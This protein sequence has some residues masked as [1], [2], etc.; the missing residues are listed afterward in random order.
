MDFFFLLFYEPQIYLFRQNHGYFHMAIG[1]VPLRWCSTHITLTSYCMFILCVISLWISMDL[2]VGTE[3]IS[4]A[5][6]A[7]L[8]CILC[9]NI[10]S[11]SLSVYLF[12]LENEIPPLESRRV[13]ARACTHANI[14]RCRRT[15]GWGY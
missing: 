15:V 5:L 2:S 12:I 9:L 10:F 8:L 13:R 6:R 14:I 1:Q 3:Q 11:F 4:E 7:I